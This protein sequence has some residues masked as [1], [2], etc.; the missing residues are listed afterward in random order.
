MLRKVSST[1]NTNKMSV[2]GLTFVDIDGQS[3]VFFLRY[4]GETLLE[5]IN[6]FGLTF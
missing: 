3:M 6:I 4:M 1:I 2:L 5:K